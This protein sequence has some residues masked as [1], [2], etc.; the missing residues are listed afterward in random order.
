MNFISLKKITSIII[1]ACTNLLT[2]S[3]SSDD[4]DTVDFSQFDANNV[5]GEMDV[6]RAIYLEDL[7]TN[8]LTVEWSKPSKIIGDNVTYLIYIDG[9]Q[10]QKMD[11]DYSTYE[12]NFHSYKCCN[13][14]PG[15]SYNIVIVCVVN[16]VII[17]N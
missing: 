15:N 11:I 6:K 12:S 2:F 1:I 16:N 8:A 13:L 9:V 3:C 14:T 17:I 5:G 10:V 7:T 4:S